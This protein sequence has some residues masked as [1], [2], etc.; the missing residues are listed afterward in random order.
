M[1]GLIVSSCSKDGNKEEQG[2]SDHI[3]YPLKI[4]RTNTNGTAVIYE[5]EY[6]V[7]NQFK[8]IK[9]YNADSVYNTIQNLEIKNSA[10][11]RIQ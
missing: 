4:E 8:T 6:D 10:K 3:Y 1:L 7:N 11:K 5:F 9:Y 2:P